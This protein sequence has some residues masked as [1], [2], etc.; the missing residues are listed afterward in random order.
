MDASRLNYR[1]LYYFWRVANE[2]HLTRVA[3]DLHVSQSALST[4]IRQLEGQLG[5]PLFER[6]GRTLV[7]TEAGRVVHE[8]AQGIFQLGAEL[9]TRVQEG[10]TH[11]TERLRVGHEPTLSRNFLENW[12]RPLLGRASTLIQLQAAPLEQLL[13][14]L[15]QHGLDVV[16]SNRM[17]AE[18][19]QRRWQAHRLAHQPVSL[20]GPASGAQRGWTY[21]DGLRGAS[22]ILPGP[23]SE[24]RQ[25]FDAL[26]PQG[27]FGYR[28]WAEVD[29]MALLRLLSRD[30][31]LLALLP[32][33]VVQDE[34]RNGTLCELHRLRGVE[35]NFYAITAPRLFEPASLRLL[36]RR[37]MRQML[38]APGDAP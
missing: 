36:L 7:M 26:C 6:R 37:P 18:S 23:S 9:W 32:P 29:D 3:A 1:H 2:G 14:R 5:S 20:V 17:P 27:E 21:P 4:Q 33:V 13:A 12:L 28:I 16:L 15:D 30:G 34:L 22:L 24:I 11:A 8:Y 19:Q 10:A 31:G 25:R 35:E 38:N